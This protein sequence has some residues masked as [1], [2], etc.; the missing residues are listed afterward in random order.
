MG[1]LAIAKITRGGVG[2]F[3]YTVSP[4]AGGAD[5]HVTATTRRAAVPAAAT[6]AL[7]DLN[8]GSYAITEHAPT[9]NAGRWTSVRVTCDGAKHKPGQPVKVTIQTGKTTACT[10]VNAFVPAG[11]ISLSKVTNGRIGAVA[12]LIAARIGQA[13][14]YHQIAVTHR[15]GVA[16]N[17]IPGG[18]ANKTDH[19]ALG[20]YLIAEQA[21]PS[22]KSHWILLYVQCNGQLVPFNRGAIAVTLT[23]AHPHMHC[24]YHDQFKSRPAPPPPPPP[25]PPTPP[26]P[27]PSPP[28]PPAPPSPPSPAPTPAYS[29]TDLSVTKQAL[30]PFAVEGES[31]T[32]RL[33]VHNKGPDPAAHVILVDKPSGKAKIV[34]ARP[35]TG[36]CTIG[37]LI[38]CRLGNLQP[39]A[40]VSIMVRLIP[41]TSATPFVNR[42]VV[43]GATAEAT[44]ANNLSHSTI[45][46]ITPP[47]H[48]IACPSRVTPVAH[49][50]C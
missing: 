38:I 49:A 28:S 1:G 35:S 40:T 37:K 8:P 42:A 36:Q 19:L 22:V 27:P 33:T 50:A 2:S 14:Q 7:T 5:R 15:Q 20:R 34:Y 16:A 41:E 17:A 24:T 44:L 30:D 47:S 11:S 25:T 3:A 39:D 45:R 32:Y 9:S 43:G 12:F 21:P 23:P 31:V 46:V 18:S 4:T 48:P 6:P 10:F 26:S 13:R 29:A